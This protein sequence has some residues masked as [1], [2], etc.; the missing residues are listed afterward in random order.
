MQ[1]WLVLLAALS[2]LLTA[3]TAPQPAPSET[4]APV[5]ATVA[6]PTATVVQ[7]PSATATAE[8]TPTLEASP[9]V[10]LNYCV[11]CHTD[12][13]KLVATGKVEEAKPK[14]SEGAG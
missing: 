1:S 10:A 14:E 3:C 6:P 12:K 9:T 5:P 13:E 11:D 8:S 4:A 2:V 7:A